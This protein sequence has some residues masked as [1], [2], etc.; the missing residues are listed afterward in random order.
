MS[1]ILARKKVM[2]R[3]VAEGGRLEAVTLL[4]ASPNLVTAIKTLEKDGYEAVQLGAGESRKMKKPQREALKGLGQ[5]HILRE[6]RGVSDLRRG[7]KVTVA[8]FAPG[9]AVKI[10]GVSKGKGF[11]GTIK[12]HGF[13]RGP[14]THGHDHHRAPGSIGPM[15][16]PRVMPGMKMAGR[17]GGK[18]ITFQTTILAIDPANNQLLIKGP[19]PGARGSWVVISKLQ[20]QSSR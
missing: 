19:V 8:A 10:Q 2:S 1:G 17:L 11:A 16:L 13:H 14:E 9:E 18:T 6:I 12:R 4:E 20:N 7:D 3:I 15:G 5:F